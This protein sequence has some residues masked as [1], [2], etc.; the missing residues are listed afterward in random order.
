M[1]IIL[2]VA[3]FLIIVVIAVVMVVN[4]VLKS[5]K[6]RNILQAGEPK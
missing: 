2:G 1:R 3:S 5:R 4:E 6:S